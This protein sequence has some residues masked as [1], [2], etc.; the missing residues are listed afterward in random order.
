MAYRK[1]IL[2]LASALLCLGASVGFSEGSD[3]L[4]ES[5]V[6]ALEQKRGADAMKSFAEWISIHEAQGVR[7]P[8]AHR[9]LAIAAQMDNKPGPAGVH[10]LTSATLRA[11][12][13]S[14]WETAE[15]LSE[16]QKEIGIRDSVTDYNSFRFALIFN[17]DWAALAAAL[18]LWCSI[19]AGVMY[20][21]RR[22]ATIPAFLVA[23]SFAFATLSLGA[24]A[25]R[26]FIARFAVVSGLKSAT[27]YKS[28]T[29]DPSLRLI[30]LP[31]GT[32]VQL[33]DTEGDLIPISGPVSG[34]LSRDAIVR[35]SQ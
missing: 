33:S 15:R 7:S 4:W 24:W 12:P 6:R 27:L 9:N 8:Q 35:I 29:A 20:R 1:L 23:C 2:R 17:R 31:E 30:D 21:L 16:M 19:S 18:S 28:A 13:F 25:N 11:S 14:N 3:P 22:R 5:G 10:L 34:W 32:V 26:R